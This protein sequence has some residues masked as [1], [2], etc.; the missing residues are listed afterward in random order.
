M[1]NE[2]LPKRL[3]DKNFFVSKPILTR[4]RGKGS[5][6]ISALMVITGLIV[7]TA[8]TLLLVQKAVT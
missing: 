1:S 8:L 7:A 3:F 4:G 2:P 6:K 5:S